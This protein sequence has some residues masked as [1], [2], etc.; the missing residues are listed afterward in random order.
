MSVDAILLNRKEKF[1]EFI[2]SHATCGFFATRNYVATRKLLRYC[3]KIREK[4]MYLT[5]LKYHIM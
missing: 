3:L 4:I 2:T 1:V 5:D